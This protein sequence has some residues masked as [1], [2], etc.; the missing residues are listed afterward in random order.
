MHDI[1]ELERRWIKYKIK[2]YSLF[3]TLLI[4]VIVLIPFVVFFSPNPLHVSEKNTTSVIVK[5]SVPKEQKKTI[6]IPKVNTTQI[7]QTDEKLFLQPSLSFIDN[8][9]TPLSINAPKPIPETKIQNTIDTKTKYTPQIKAS[10]QPSK[11][12]VKPNTAIE[13]KSKKIDIQTHNVD[14]VD[15][16]MQDVIQRFKKTNNPTLGLFLA[17]KYYDMKQYDLA[18]NYALLTNQLDSKVDMSWIIFSKSLV[19]L[20][21]KDKAISTLKSYINNSHSKQAISLLD[22]IETGRFK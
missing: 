13:Q 19:K 21:Q 4:F 16:D 10:V 14:N 5:N 18:Y 7:K 8:M 2:S 15:E 6:Q 9:D 17:K 3:I 11:T 12:I 22:E 1:Q 20:G